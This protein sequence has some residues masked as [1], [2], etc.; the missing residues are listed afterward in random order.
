MERW[1]PSSS[2]RLE[3]LGLHS[4][5]SVRL[6][7]HPGAE[8][9]WFRCGS[10][11]VQ[12]LPDNVTETRR[13]TKLGSISTIEHLMSAFAGTGVSDAE[14]ELDAP[15]LPAMDGSARD[16]VHAILLAGLEKVGEAP[17]PPLFS[18]IFVQDEGLSIAISKGDGHWSYSYDCSPRWPGKM[19]FDLANLPKDYPEEVAP[20][21]TFAFSEEVEPARAANL[22]LGLDETSVLILG[23]AGYENRSRYPDEPARHKLLDLIGDLYLAGFPISQLNVSA[24]RSG[25]SANVR[26]AAL[27]RQAILR[28]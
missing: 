13:C 7:V 11:R 19:D 9:I 26:A 23:V 5:A 20:A 4:G 6:T 25:H 28:S 12:A 10:E 3:G 24:V 22:G 15:E 1:T 16:F 18:R 14:V 27:L 21:R 2:F 17:I 8:G